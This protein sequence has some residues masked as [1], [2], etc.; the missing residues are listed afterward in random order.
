MQLHSASLVVHMF[1][2]LINHN[3]EE[4]WNLRKV[5]HRNVC[6]TLKHDRDSVFKYF[7]LLLQVYF[8]RFKGNRFRLLTNVQEQRYN[9][10]GIFIF[11]FGLK[12][13]SIDMKATVIILL[14]LGIAVVNTASEGMPY[15]GN[16]EGS[17][18]F[19]FLLQFSTDC[20]FY[21]PV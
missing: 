19:C 15:S 13:A 8:K 9:K 1:V 14:L 18:L 4:L 7:K 21:T 5:Q 10:H 2:F 12:T 16:Q 20:T 11:I 6:T 3:Q 17:T